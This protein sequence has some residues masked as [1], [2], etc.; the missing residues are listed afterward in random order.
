MGVVYDRGVKRLAVV[1]VLLAACEMPNTPPVRTPAPPAGPQVVGTEWEL[2]A[3]QGKPVLSGTRVTLIFDEKSAGG[4]SGCNWYGG[5]YSKSAST[6]QVKQVTSTARGCLK[7]DGTDKQERDYYMLLQRPLT[8]AAE[9]QRLTLKDATGAA[10]LEFKPIP[11][12]PMDPAALVGTR[13]QVPDTNIT[14]IFATVETYRGFGG[15]RDYRGTYRAKRDKINFPSITMT[16]TECEQPLAVRRAEEDFTNYL[17]ESE[18]YVMTAD[19][20]AIKTVGGRQIELVR[21]TPIPPITGAP[22]LLPVDEAAK[23]PSFVAFRAS[24]IEIV[25]KRDTKALLATIA[26]DIKT[27][28]GGGGGRNDFIKHW[29]LDTD[30]SPIWEE[31]DAILALGGKFT[32]PDVFW[33]PYVY[34]AWPDDVDSFEYVAAVRNDVVVRDGVKPIATLDHHLVRIAAK[35]PIRLGNP[36]APRRRVVLPDKREGWVPVDEIR[37]PVDYRAAFDKK[38]GVWTMTALVA[39]D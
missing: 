39:G 10:V 27:D 33:A 7:P 15:C 37:S 16:A 36:H 19:R 11:S 5:E 8:I 23:D 4:Y 3:M 18:R 6:L 38:N 21:A 24:L 17:S 30:L 29:K 26:D 35:D 9:P 20:L 32:T 25:R 34:S 14:L 22:R 2:I 13:W 28:F 31:L 1:L 12:T